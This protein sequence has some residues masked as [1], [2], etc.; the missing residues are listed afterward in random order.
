LASPTTVDRSRGAPVGTLRFT[1]PRLLPEP[2]LDGLRGLAVAAVVLYHGGATAVP[3]GYLGVSLFFTLSGYLITSLVLAGHRA[4]GRVGLGAFWVRRARRLLPA[5]LAT[6]AGALAATAALAPDRLVTVAGDTRAAVL[7][8]ANWHLVWAERSYDTLFAAPSPLQHLW[9][10]AIEEQFYVVFPLVAAAALALG[11]RRALTAVLA[12]LA[13]GSVAAQ[14]LTTDPDLA[15]YGTHTRAAEL[16]AG[17][18]LACLRPLPVVPSV[19]DGAV[20][21]P[22]KLDFAT[23]AGGRPRLR[24]SHVAGPLAVAAFVAVCVLA[25]ASPAALPRGAL[26]AVAVLNTVVV[27]LATR[28]GPARRLLRARPLT[29]LGLVSYGLYLVHWP[30]FVFVTPE[31]AGLDGVPLLALR[32]ALSGCLAA[33]SFRWIEQP[34]RRGRWPSTR[35]LGP[36][37]VTGAAVVLVAGAVVPAVVSTG[38]PAGPQEDWLLAASPTSAPAPGPPVTAAS[39]TAT[40]PVRIAVVGDSSARVIGRGLA[41]WAPSGTD[42]LNLGLNACSLAP[43]QARFGTEGSLVVEACRLDEV[44][45]PLAGFDPDVV[46]VAAGVMGV[47]DHRVPGDP[48]GPWRHLGDPAFDAEYRA[49]VGDAVDRIHRLAP[50][51]VVAWTTGPYVA[52]DSC[53]QGCPTAEPARM[54]RFNAVAGEALAARPGV[55]VVDLAGRLNPPG[56]GTGVDRQARPDGIH[57]APAYAEA[58]AE[59][60]LGPALAAL[61]DP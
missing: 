6:A 19:A 22:A 23:S 20:G 1:G 53:P 59:R 39:A 5:A 49:A 44:W 54:D 9:S 61:A 30:V 47:A 24:F 7:Y 4:T 46:V 21:G 48:P 40:A 50:G 28:A 32:L 8:L 55:R 43:G 52:A 14:L 15:Y 33:I 56:G 12:V 13:A 26:A 36:A 41:D 42:V 16:L 58:L 38:G 27:G 11:G 45:A 51:A 29:R 3:G 60:W 57:L 18:L 37:A 2:A 10:L 25:P 31:R 17:C 35:R 34:V